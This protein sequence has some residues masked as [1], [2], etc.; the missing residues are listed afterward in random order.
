MLKQN[1]EKQNNNRINITHLYNAVYII[2]INEGSKID[3]ISF[4]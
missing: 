2:R 1:C 4:I 3:R